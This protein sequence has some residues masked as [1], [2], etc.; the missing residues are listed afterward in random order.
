MRKYAVLGLV[1]TGAALVLAGCALINGSGKAKTETRNVSG[2]SS[3][4]IS[5]AGELEI[6]QTGMESLH[7]TADDNILPYLTAQVVHGQLQLGIKP[8][9]SIRTNTP[10]Q[11]T[12]T[13]KRLD[14]LTISGSADA[15]MEKLE[16]N[17]LVLLVSGS[18][19]AMVSNLRA[20]STQATIT[21]SGSVTLTGETQSQQV[22]ISGSGDY[23]GDQL[24]STSAIA[25]VSGAGN[26]KLRVTQSLDA[27]TSG[28]GDI[29]YSGNPAQVSSHATGSGS[30]TSG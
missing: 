20:Q 30:I 29:T 10:I 13:V 6:Q 4:A 2:F 21:G 16:T 22:T 1:T 12:L 11:Y 17:S 9:V 15:T 3:V 28:S 19:N 23:Y 24:T 26:A 25:Q 14:G 27:T 7:I 8:D 5:G 18:G